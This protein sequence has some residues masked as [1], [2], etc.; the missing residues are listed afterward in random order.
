MDCLNEHCPVPAPK[1]GLC[2]DCAI[3]QLEAGGYKFSEALKII[4]IIFGE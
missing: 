4:K 1:L 2:E 3:E